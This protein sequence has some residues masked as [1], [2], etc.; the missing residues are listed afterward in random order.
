MENKRGSEE[1]LKRALYSVA[2]ACSLPWINFPHPAPGGSNTS[3]KEVRVKV[4]MVG[5]CAFTPLTSPKLL[6][7]LL[8]ALYSKLSLEEFSQLF[9]VFVGTFIK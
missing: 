9:F 3:L 1:R 5:V 6:P 7:A 8:L 2:P 4:V